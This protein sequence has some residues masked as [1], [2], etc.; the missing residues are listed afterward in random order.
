MTIK[1][2]TL[3]AAR[4]RTRRAAAAR[5]AA[6]ESAAAEGAA[7][8]AAETAARRGAP[9]TRAV[10]VRGAA[11][12]VEGIVVPVV[13]A[14]RPAGRIA[15][16]AA[17]TA[18]IDPRL[19]RAAAARAPVDIRP[20]TASERLRT[21]RTTRTMHDIGTVRIVMVD[22]S[23][24][25]PPARAPAAPMRVAVPAGTP[26]PRRPPPRIVP[27]AVPRTVPRAVPGTVP[28]VP[29]ETPAPTADREGQS[30]RT[31]AVIPRIEEDDGPPPRTEHGGNVFGLD[32]HLV[33]HHDHVIEGRI[34]GGNVIERPAVTGVDI[35][36]GHVVRRRLEAAQPAGIGA[37]V[38]VGQHAPVGIGVVF[39]ISVFGGCGLGFGQP[40]LPFGAARF[41]R[42]LARLGLRLL[43]TGDLRPVV[44]G[45]EV[46]GGVSRRG[47]IGRRTARKPR[48]R[49]EGPDP[50]IQ[51]FHN[52]LRFAWVLSEKTKTVP[53]LVFLSL[54]CSINAPGGE[55][56]LPA[57]GPFGTKIG[58]IPEPEATRGGQTPP[59]EAFFSPE[60]NFFR[61]KMRGY[62]KY[63][64]ICSPKTMVSGNDLQGEMPEWSI[65]PHS[66]C[67]VR[68]TVPGVRIPLSP[69]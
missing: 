2:D 10:A 12:P 29:A 30:G 35:A 40:G 38:I 31:P 1:A 61:P 63:V 11:P 51:R 4:T 24:A 64:Y 7:A 6:R 42:G 48:G 53:V 45:I 56:L 34:V 23:P 22:R 39:V 27:G 3:S 67:G 8:A 50:K 66:K 16:A 15:A 28:R 18:L 5:T 52:T 44:Q 9:V 60:R 47:V 25:G 58:I 36:R 62:K 49:Q 21:G 55:I 20:R 26:A 13:P 65:G 32:P 37:L 17:V 57:G 68:A 41:G 14:D 19:P 54:P 46:V 69:Q 43:L 59:S 33:A